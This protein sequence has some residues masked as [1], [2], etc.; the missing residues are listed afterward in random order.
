MSRSILMVCNG[1]TI[2]QVISEYS[3]VA[4]NNTWVQ[5]ILHMQPKH[6]LELGT[7]R[8]TT[9]AL[10]MSVLP[11][12]SMFTTINYSYPE[13]EKYGE[14]LQPWDQD[15]RLRRIIGDTTDPATLDK[16]EGGVDLLFIDTIHDAY[17]A[18]VELYLWQRKLADG[19][20]VIVD[21]LNH[22]DM[23]KFWDLIPYEK[24]GDATS[25]GIFRYN[26]SEPYSIR[27]TDKSAS[28]YKQRR[29][30]IDRP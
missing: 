2:A 19:A 21:D 14:L 18:D 22:K 30:Y 3:A 5:R 8:G 25:Q 6:V 23:M 7:G 1:K 20:I 28:D 27:I 13:N 9:G 15:K 17:V 29:I 4:S 24:V 12:T 10:I 16:V 26:A 11:P